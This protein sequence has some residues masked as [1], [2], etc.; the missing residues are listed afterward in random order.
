MVRP[1]GL[2]VIGDEHAVVTVEV[3]Q[4]DERGRI[5]LLPRWGSRV[6]WLRSSTS[7]VEALMILVEP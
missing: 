6:E 7:D 3:A 4:I 2:S 5:N 1:S